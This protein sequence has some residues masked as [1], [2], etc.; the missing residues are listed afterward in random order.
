MKTFREQETLLEFELLDRIM[1]SH[2]LALLSSLG[3]NW[4]K[5]FKQKLQIWDLNMLHNQMTYIQNLIRLR[6]K[7]QLF[8]S[9]ILISAVI[10]I[11]KPRMT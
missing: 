7:V 6:N 8:S 2:V 10:T 1:F 4:S 3:E 9:V 11:S 5:N